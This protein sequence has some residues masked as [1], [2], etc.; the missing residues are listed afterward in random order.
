MA[1]DKY[2][3]VLLP[4]GRFIN[5]DLYIPQTTN[6]AGEPLVIKKGVNAGQPRVNFYIGLAIPKT[7]GCAHWSQ[8]VSTNPRIGAWGKKIWDAGYQFWGDLAS[9]KKNFAWKIVDG[10]STDYDG[11]NPPKRYCDKPNYNG[12]WIISLGKMSTPK[13]VNSDGSQYLLDKDVVKPGYFIQIAT[14]IS[15]NNSDLNQGIHINHDIISYQYAG[16]EIINGIDPATIGFGSDKPPA[17]AIQI[18]VAIP[19]S[20]QP[21]ITPIMPPIVP[22]H[23][24]VNNA[25]PIPPAPPV[26][27][28]L[29]NGA[30]YESYIAAN[31]TDQQLSEAGL[32]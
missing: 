30:T 4:V 19:N 15:S 12:H 20:P 29:K 6:M 1:N 17:G 24:F 16:E 8:E 7:P 18:N 14:S 13:I 25:V 26:G 9:Q 11:S 23:N 27:R 2:V 22:N 31:W 10:D 5:G 28:L 32:L 21:V 3:N